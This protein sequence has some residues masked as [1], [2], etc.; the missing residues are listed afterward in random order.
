MLQ[1]A[2]S[3]LVISTHKGNGDTDSLRIHFP[4]PKSPT[5]Y[6]ALHQS[7]RCET[8]PFHCSAERRYNGGTAEVRRSQGKAKEGVTWE[9]LGKCPKFNQFYFLC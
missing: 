4:F 3:H 8:S 2:T 9:L 1:F 7:T 6:P 5:S